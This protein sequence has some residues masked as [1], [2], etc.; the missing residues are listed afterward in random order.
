MRVVNLTPHQI[1]ETE[2]G[3]SFP[4]AGTVGRV[5]VSYEADGDVDGIPVFRAIYGQVQDL[6][7][8]QADTIFIVSGMVK[9][10]IPARADVVAPGELV[11]DESGK[12]VG[13]R[14]FKK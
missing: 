1:N 7:E 5:A 10:A 4:P 2:T 11:R 14:G 8:P 13:C 9:A 3:R 12:P 6:P